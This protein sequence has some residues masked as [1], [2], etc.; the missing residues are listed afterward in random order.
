MTEME[1]ALF[2]KE[3]FQDKI[4]T[5]RR[6]LHAMDGFQPVERISDN[7]PQSEEMEQV[8]FIKTNEK[9]NA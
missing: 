8:A 4:L 3:Y 9:V 6:K 1:E 7:L 5:M 2:S